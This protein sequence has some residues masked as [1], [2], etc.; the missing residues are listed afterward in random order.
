MISTNVSKNYILILD[1][2]H[3][4]SAAIMR[5]LCHSEYLGHEGE[6]SYRE[7]P[8]NLFRLLTVNQLLIQ[9]FQ[10]CVAKLWGNGARDQGCQ[11]NTKKQPKGQCLRI[12]HNPK[13]TQG[14]LGYFNLNFISYSSDLSRF[15]RPGNPKVLSLSNFLFH[16]IN[17]HYYIMFHIT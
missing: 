16:S 9:N 14:S 4:I 7:L 3:E 5:R 10:V 17:Q 8:V 6:G 13:W 2:V 15:Y 11:V 12:V 1:C